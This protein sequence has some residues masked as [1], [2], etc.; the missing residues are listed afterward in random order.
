MKMK[1][2]GNTLFLIILSI[3]LVVVLL[4]IIA[5]RGQSAL[6][7]YG[8]FRPGQVVQISDDVVHHITGIQLCGNIN[9]SGQYSDGGYE[10]LCLS[11][12]ELRARI[13]NYKEAK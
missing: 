11:P 7:K 9:L 5:S 4:S 2:G 1:D 13:D 3:T 6:E 10:Y 12:K 8:P